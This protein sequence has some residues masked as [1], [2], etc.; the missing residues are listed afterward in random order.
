MT[1]QELDA[2]LASKRAALLAEQKRQAAELRERQQA[3]QQRVGPWAPSR[4]LTVSQRRQHRTVTS[5]VTP[6]RRR[7]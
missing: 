5:K 4:R 6:I 2:M 3:G 1:D 7:A